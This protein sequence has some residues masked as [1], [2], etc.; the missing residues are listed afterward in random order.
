M[1]L[2]KYKNRG[3]ARAGRG[4]ASGLVAQDSGWWACGRYISKYAA[5]WCGACACVQRVCAYVFAQSI[6]VCVPARVVCVRVRSG[7][8]RARD[9]YGVRGC[10]PAAALMLIVSTH[11]YARPMCQTP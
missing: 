1:Q 7:Y 3:R 5:T 8:V 2:D 6:D 9:A 10:P 11:A 4:R